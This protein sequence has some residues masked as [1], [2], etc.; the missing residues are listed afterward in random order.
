MRI[1][2]VFALLAFA[3]C[4]TLANAGP[5]SETYEECCTNTRST[6]PGAPKYNCGG[7][8]PEPRPSTSRALRAGTAD[9]T[10]AFSSVPTFTPRVRGAMKTFSSPTPRFL[11]GSC[12]NLTGFTTIAGPNKSIKCPAG[13]QKLQADLNRG[14]G[15]QYIYT[16]YTRMDTGHILEGI[17]AVNG[18][19]NNVACPDGFIRTGVNVNMGTGGPY[20]FMCVR[21]AASPSDSITS[22]TNFGVEYA[23]SPTASNLECG[24]GAEMIP[25]NFNQ[26]N[27]GDVV[28]ICVQTCKG[29]NGG[30]GGILETG[31]QFP[32]EGV[33]CGAGATCVNNTACC[34]WPSPI[35][36]NGQCCQL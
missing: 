23:T 36:C 30:C 19:S 26:G 10:P 24:H 5:V 22:I 29:Q 11:G 2:H 31:C 34:K 12:T 6:Y 17:T 32:L 3:A 25:L 4:M 7:C 13:Y 16:C 9:P 28:R 33:C 8:S 27:S 14:V 1:L 35:P 15:S 20:I 21:Y 18:T